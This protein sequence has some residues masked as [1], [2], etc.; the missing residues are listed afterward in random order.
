M[1]SKYKFL[2]ALMLFLYLFAHP[3][4]KAVDTVA[5]DKVRNKEVLDS[6][7]LKVIDSFFAQSVAE[8]VRTR[9]FT[10]ISKIRALILARKNSDWPTNQG[11]Y[12][13][14]FS[15]SANKYIPAALKSS[16]ELTPADRAFKMKLNLLILIDSLEDLKLAQN[17]LGLMD[18]SN[19]AIRYWAVHCLS[20]EG[21]IAKLNSDITANSGF[22][23]RILTGFSKAS[24]DAE[25]STLVMIARFAAKVDVPTGQDLLLTIAKNRIRRYETG[26]SGQ[27][28]LDGEILKLLSYRI[29]TTNSEKDKAL[30]GRQFAQLFSYVI[31]KYALEEK[32]LSSTEKQHL[33]SVMV[34]TEKSCIGALLA[35][36]QIKIKMALSQDNY[37]ALAEEHDRLLGSDGKAGEL[38][39]KLNFNYGKGTDGSEMLGPVKL[40]K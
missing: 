35:K 24:E 19:L 38:G 39:L 36:D 34:E 32:T 4:C 2:T 5:I 37:S 7:D 13:S 18:N 1:R 12:V 6:A 21:I 22:A 9:D 31:Q 16:G 14:Q 11:Q 33:V 8:L 3:V 23:K 20:N 27:E 28:L 29:Q 40:P 25:P 15:E 17:V 26:Q 30:L 10:A